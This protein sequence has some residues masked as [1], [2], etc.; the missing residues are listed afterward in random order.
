M[1]KK[2]LFFQ[3]QTPP[4]H[5]EK[6]YRAVQDNLLRNKQ[7]AE[8]EKQTWSSFWSIKTWGFSTAAIVAVAS[9]FILQRNK[10]ENPDIL[11]FADLEMTS[12]DVDI[13]AMDL[14]I[15]DDLE[16]LELME[17]ES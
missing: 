2:D 13:L 7:I 17:E 10:S 8:S 11:A 16:M 4:G 6:V 1:K 9:Y 15:I 14:D 3:E 12:E 5:D